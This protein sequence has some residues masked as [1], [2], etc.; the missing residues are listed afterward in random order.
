MWGRKIRLLQ[1]QKS[2]NSRCFSKQ[3]PKLVN[4]GSLML[5]KAALFFAEWIE[6]SGELSFILKMSL[7]FLVCGIL[8]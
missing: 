8:S 1:G 7:I 3:T 5:I 2:K 4:F 6:H